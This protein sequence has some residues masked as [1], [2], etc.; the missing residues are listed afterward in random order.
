MKRI[1]NEP[2]AAALAFG[3]TQAQGDKQTRNLLVFDFG[4]GTLD[5]TIM[6]IESGSMNFKVHIVCLEFRFSCSDFAKYECFA[7]FQLHMRL[8][9]QLTIEIDNMDFQMH[10]I[11]LVPLPLFF[12]QVC[13][14]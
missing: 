4:G 6:E 3:V 9:S 12:I 10:S 13:D 1:I 2:T 5:V 14:S 8:H 11:F 7:P